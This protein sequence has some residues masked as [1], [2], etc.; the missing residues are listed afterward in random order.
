MKVVVDVHAIG[1]KKLE[2]SLL[3]TL[4]KKIAAM[5]E[6]HLTNMEI[7]ELHSCR[8][9]VVAGEVDNETGENRISVLHDN[10]IWLLVTNFFF[11]LSLDDLI[12]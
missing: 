1:Y 10:E 12:S 9:V 11:S 4:N 6:G 3:G 5:T 2:S 8:F 7:D